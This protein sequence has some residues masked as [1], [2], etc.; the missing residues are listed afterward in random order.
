MPGD[1]PFLVEHADLAY[2]DQ[3]PTFLQSGFWGSFK[4]RFDWKAHA[5]SVGQTPLL[6]LTRPLA[7]GVAF[8]YVPWGPQLSLGPQLSPPDAA[9][10]SRGL[11]EIAQALRPLLPRNICFIR[12][13]PPW[14]SQGENVEA[15]QIAPPL[16]RAGSD[17]QAPD[18]VLVDLSPPPEE[19]LSR[20]KPKWRYN[21]N[22]AAKKGVTVRCLRSGAE[23]EAGLTTFYALLKE[24]AV[25]DGIAIHSFVYYRGLFEQT[26]EYAAV[27]PVDVRL[28]L[29]E[30][31]GQALAGI[32]TLFRGGEGV[33]LYGASS[34]Q[35]RNLMAPY[36]LQ[37][38]AMRDARGSGCAFYDLFGI[39]PSS[40]PDHPMAGLYRFKTGFIGDAGGRIIHRPG[41]WD[42]PCRP[43][44][45]L[46]FKGAEKWRK[47]LRDRRKKGRS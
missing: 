27:P 15:P 1:G 6:V 3:S 46:C 36:A 47:K 42:Y 22:L 7:L 20:M 39:P 16:V 43:L 32:V 24:T 26:V 41:S 14:H 33:Y 31:E 5:F 10:A 13:D 8:A 9:A 30:Y 40:G 45:T 19:I 35:H 11:A 4:A 21:I 38:Q 28:Y 12:F 23:L 29:A 25:R 37:W 18:T 44:L 2:C 34:N 17:I